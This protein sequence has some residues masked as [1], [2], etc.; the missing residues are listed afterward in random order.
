[1]PQTS[2]KNTPKHLSQLGKGEIPNGAKFAE[3]AV[4][5][6]QCQLQNIGIKITTDQNFLLY[7]TCS[8]SAITVCIIKALSEC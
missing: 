2:N 5:I 8:S 3:I 4:K 7:W 1:M 6:S